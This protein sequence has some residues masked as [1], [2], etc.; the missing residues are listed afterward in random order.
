M[1]ENS[2]TLFVTTATIAW[3]FLIYSLFLLLT[4]TPQ[5]QIV[6]LNSPFRPFDSRL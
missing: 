4:L 1:G 6:G 5:L 3:R 2:Q